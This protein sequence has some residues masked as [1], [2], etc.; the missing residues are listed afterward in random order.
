MYIRQTLFDT[1][2]SNAEVSLV[3]QLAVVKQLVR[4]PLMI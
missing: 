4:N 3:K 1:F 2:A